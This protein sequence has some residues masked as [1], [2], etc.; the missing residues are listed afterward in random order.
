MMRSAIFLCLFFTALLANAQRGEV[1]LPLQGNTLLKSFAQA[2]PEPIGN[3]PAHGFYKNAGIYPLIELIHEDADTLNLN[4]WK[5]GGVQKKGNLLVFNAL[6]ASGAAYA[7]GNNS[8]GVAD[9][10]VSVPLNLTLSNGLSYL[11]FIFSTGS[12]WQSTDSLVVEALTQSGSYQQLWV[13]PTTANSLT[14]VVLPM[15]NAL[16]QINF[17]FRLL[18][19]TNRIVSNTETFILHRITLTDKWKLPAYENF[20]N[21]QIDST[22]NPL[23]W[24]A[25]TAKVNAG[26]IMNYTRGNV[27]IFDAYNQRGQLYAGSAGA[28]DTLLSNLIDVQ[29]YQVTD[30]VYLRFYYRALQASSNADTLKL[31]LKNNLGIWQQVWQR[32]APAMNGTDTLIMP[33]NIGRFRHANFQFRLISAGTHNADDTAIFAASGFHIGKKIFI[34]F[35]DDFSASVIYPSLSRFTSRHVYI[36]NHFPKNA[37]SRNV[38]TFDGLDFRGNPY[39]VGRGYC[40]TL[41]SQPINLHGFKPADSIYLTFWIQPM[42][43]GESPNAGDSLVIRF[44]NSGANSFDFITVRNVSP[45]TLKKDSFIEIRLPVVDIDY[46]HDDFQF[47]ILNIG[48]RTGNLNHW[49]VD[50]IRLDKGRGVSDFYQD[51]A[52]TSFP[53]SMLKKYQS[54]PVKH[55]LAGPNQFLDD[56]QKMGMRNNN[57][58]GYSVNFSREVFAPDFARLDSF[59]NINPN[60]SPLK[61]T[62]V[63]IT[64]LTP[65]PAQNYSGDSLVFTSRYA[66]S[67]S[68]SDNIF[69]NDTATAQTILSNYFAYDDG[70]AEAGYAIRNATGAVALGYDLSVQDTLYG[71]S[72]FF[73]RGSADVTGRSFSLMVWQAVNTNGNATGE[74]VLKKVLLSGPAYTNIIN[75]FYYYKFDAPIILPPGKF[76]IGWEQDQMFE[77]NIGLDENYSIN[78]TPGVNPDMWYRI[79]GLWD[80]TILTG[81]LMMRPIFG[82]W[83]NPPVGCAEQ[84]ITPKLQAEIYPN[85]ASDLIYVYMPL[86]EQAMA[87]IYDLGGKLLIRENVNTGESIALNTLAPGLYVIKLTD[88]ATGASATKKIILTK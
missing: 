42:G 21:Y 85:P 33:I 14:E 36:N 59:G 41:L 5:K 7:A 40:D 3:K 45:A 32:A 56:V 17:Q 47:L 4:R 44:R 78:D 51:V 84:V 34:P 58:I 20:V 49:H 52:I 15:N 86:C 53:S 29:S 74:I 38:A 26:N 12:T 80:R 76:Y 22:P 8:Y 88:H 31:Q 30:S 50:Y 18:L 9:T 43:W 60:L 82:K 13:S 73:N 11:S 25:A 66:I 28:C 64:K 72:M 63:D 35:L 77:L 6:N 65:L 55:F 67:G 39:G 69:S 87:E 62:L 19:Y 61:P 54:M 2:Y 75:G 27:A 24:T 46:L 16:N 83:L 10:L 70:S 79:D 23:L 71:I 37:P 48:S 68:G 1:K 81:A 57:N